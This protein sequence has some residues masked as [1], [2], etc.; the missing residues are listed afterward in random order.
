MPNNN[1]NKFGS[2]TARYEVFFCLL[3]VLVIL[4]VYWPVSYHGFILLD[5]D[6]YITANRHVIEGPSLEN[7]KWA[8][9][10][11]HAGF[12]IPLTWLS[13]MLDSW[14]YGLNA[15]GHHMTNVIFHCLNTLLL[16]LAFHRLTG[17]LWRSAMVALLFAVHPLHV[18]SVAWAS[19]RKD[20]LF[21]FFW[22]LTMIA[23]SRYAERPGLRR[24]WL[25][26]VFFALGL[27]AKPM[28]V[29]LPFVLLLMDYWPLGRWKPVNSALPGPSR[30][31]EKLWHLVLEKIPL[32]FLSALGSV[33]TFSLQKSG[34][35]LP[36]LQ[37]LSP[38]A[39]MSN[40]LVAYGK[41]IVKMIWPH[42]LAVLYPLSGSP[43]AASLGL[44]VFVLAAISA[45]VVRYMKKHAYLPV[46][47]LWFLGTFVPVI[48]IVQSGPQSMADRFAYIPFIGLYIMIAWGSACLFGRWRHQ[49]IFLGCLSTI[50]IIALLMVTRTQVGYWKNNLTLFQHTLAV[51][52]DNFVVHRNLGLAFARQA[53]FNSA[54][55]HF[56]KALAIDPAYPSTYHDI[57]TVLMLSGNHDRARLFFEQALQRNPNGAKT[58]NNLGLVLLK[59]G[60]VKEAANHFQKALQINPSFAPARQNL[61]KVQSA[62]QQQASGN[63]P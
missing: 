9:T 54:L 23:Y 42:P 37:V 18:E 52:K 46:G 43:S 50:A 27:M 12:W 5:D 45:L 24:Y 11:S 19:E 28:I 17:D 53:N 1:S 14:L 4:A 51:T 62:M 29:T 35:A 40:V 13:H 60:D 58:H 49:K 41:Y 32:F 16:F 57:G 31:T 34:G 7:I 55:L 3:L 59:L 26:I 33:V 39:R 61:R 30:K 48:G 63:N 10:T 6:V 38:A 44:S 2:A 21:A 8:F 25:V 20:V 22:M 36:S 56:Q 15:G 47:W